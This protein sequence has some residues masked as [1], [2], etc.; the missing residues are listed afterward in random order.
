MGGIL[1]ALLVAHL[2]A[3]IDAVA[4]ACDER[5]S[6]SPAVRASGDPDI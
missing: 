3:G 1:I 4:A 5:R 2:Q 6:S